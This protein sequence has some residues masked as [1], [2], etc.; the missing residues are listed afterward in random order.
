MTQ[1]GLGWRGARGCCLVVGLVGPACLPV[2]SRPKPSE[3]LLNIEDGSAT[4]TDFVTDD[5]WAIH[6]TNL[7]AVVGAIGLVSDLVAPDSRCNEYSATDYYWLLNLL[8]PGAQKVGLTYGLGSCHVRWELAQADP[9]RALRTGSGVERLDYGNMTKGAYSL[10]MNGTA[11]SGSTVVSFAI[12]LTNASYQGTCAP[13]ELAGESRT[14][15]LQVDP[16]ALFRSADGASTLFDGLWAEGLAS[17]GSLSVTVVPTHG[18]I[19]EFFVIEG[20]V[21]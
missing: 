12:G 13:S 15:T 2:D 4:V 16:T 14:V 18:A 19:Q 6:V 1:G 5:G 21:C 11:T 17:E 10:L 7:F 3:V 20:G 8:E 9:F